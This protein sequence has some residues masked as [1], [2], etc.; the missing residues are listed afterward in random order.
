M[1]QGLGFLSFLRFQGL[2]YGFL[3]VSGGCLS[4][5]EF[6]KATSGEVRGAC[7]L[8]LQALFNRRCR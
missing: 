7:G 8:G 4:F 2:G 3:V 5:I 6:M 1:V